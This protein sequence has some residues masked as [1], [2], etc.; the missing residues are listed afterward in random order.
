MVSP[1]RGTTQNCAESGHDT[2]KK[3]PRKLV[4]SKPIPRTEVTKK[5]WAYIK[6]NK[7]VDSRNPRNIR[8]DEKLR[9]IFGGSDN[10]FEIGLKALAQHYK[11]L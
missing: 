2:A 10:D 6:Q 7:L 4:G 11:K 8:P 5:L 3:S 1:N 9:A